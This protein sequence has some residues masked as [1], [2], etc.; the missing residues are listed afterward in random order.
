[1]DSSNSVRSS[2]RARN[3]RRVSQPQP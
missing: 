1:M 2:N 3:R